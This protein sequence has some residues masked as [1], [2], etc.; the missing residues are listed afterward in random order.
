MLLECDAARAH[1]SNGVGCQAAWGHAY[2]MEYTFP[3][4]DILLGSPGRPS[5]LAG[6]SC[7]MESHGFFIFPEHGEPLPMHPISLGPALWVLASASPSASPSPST[8]PEVI[9]IYFPNTTDSPSP[10]TQAP[11]EVHGFLLFHFP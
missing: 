8:M 3:L 7:Q 10:S 4:G 2:V 9:S 5:T 6:Q 1:D 11:S